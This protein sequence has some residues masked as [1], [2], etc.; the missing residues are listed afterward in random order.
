M[1]PSKNWL[2]PG[3]KQRRI[4]LM[5]TPTIQTSAA[6]QSEADFSRQQRAEAR[7]RRL[8]EATQNALRN[9]GIAREKMEQA[10]R[11]YKNKNWNEVITLTGKVLK[12]TPSTPRAT[13]LRDKANDARNGNSTATTRAITR[14]ESSSQRSQRGNRTREAS[15]Q[16]CE[17]CSI[18]DP[19]FMAKRFLDR[20]AANHCEW[21]SVSPN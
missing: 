16:Q 5:N 13:Q 7:F 1:N 8:T 11:E 9:A 15:P 20:H 14:C 12:E 10:E 19:L 17:Y 6:E 18:P 3:G 21:F 4:A 2:K